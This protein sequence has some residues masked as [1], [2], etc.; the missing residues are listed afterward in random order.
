VEVQ[1]VTPAELSRA[2]AG[3]ASAEV[4]ARVVRSI[5]D[6]AGAESIRRTDVAEALAFRHRVPGRRA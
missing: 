5:A 2:P 3:A 4:A 6:L 1:P